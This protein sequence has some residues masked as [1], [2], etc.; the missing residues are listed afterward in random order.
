MNHKYLF[1]TALFLFIVLVID[2]KSMLEH[3]SNQKKISALEEEIAEM[4]RD[5]TEIEERYF[6]LIEGGDSLEAEK[7]AREMYNMKTP[8]EEVYIIE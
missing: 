8:D 2:D 4:Q 1:V 3:I 5:S 7:Y 6:R